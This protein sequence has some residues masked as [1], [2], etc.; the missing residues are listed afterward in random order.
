MLVNANVST[1]HVDIQRSRMKKEGMKISSIVALFTLTNELS[2]EEDPWIPGSIMGLM[3]PLS[4][5][6]LLS[7]SPL[8]MQ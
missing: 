5:S 4:S 3:G 2:L 1:R 6:S 7:L 8:Q